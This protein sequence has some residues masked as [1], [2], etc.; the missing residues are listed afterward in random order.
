[1]QLFVVKRLLISTVVGLLTSWQVAH[2]L[3]I[4]E[5]TV[6]IDKGRYRVFG[7]SKIDAP[8]E[9]VFFTLMDY[10]NFHKLAG[11][12]AETKFLPG[13]EPG[14]LLAYTRFE[15][16]VLIFCK[17]I[18]KTELIDSK[19]HDFI[20]LQAIPERSDFVFSEARWTITAVGDTTLLTY[21]AEFEPDFWIPPLIGP[22]AVRRKLIRTAELIGMRIEWMQEHGLTLEQVRE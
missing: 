5:V 21:E 18:E 16:C 7:Q 6:D 10:K 4:I 2:A 1:M 12:I 15:S 3:E 17:T 14:T 19:P 9:F 13:D 22:W 8:A 20:H 11:G